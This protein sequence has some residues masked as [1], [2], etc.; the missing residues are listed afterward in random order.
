MIQKVKISDKFLFVNTVNGK[1]GFSNTENDST[2]LEKLQQKTFKNKAITAPLI[3]EQIPENIHLIIQLTEACNMACDYCFQSILNNNDIKT[4]FFNHADSDKLIEQLI[5]FS[6][7]NTT[8]TFS[9]EFTGG[10]PLLKFEE[11]KYFVNSA[12]EKK[13]SINS[14]GIKTNGTIFTKEIAEFASKHNLGICFSID[15]NK[16]SH[17]ERRKFRNGKG[18][19]EVIIENLKKYKSHGCL[20]SNIAVASRAY[21]FE[22]IFSLFEEG[23]FDSFKINKIG[24][25]SDKTDQKE[26]ALAHLNLIKKVIAKFSEE[27]IFYRLPNLFHNFNDILFSESRLKT[28]KI[29][30]PT[31][32]CNAGYNMISITPELSVYPCLEGISAD[33]YLGNLHDTS[34]LLNDIFA[35]KKFLFPFKV[36]ITEIPKCRVCVFSS[37]CKGGCPIRSKAKF[38]S[39][40]KESDSCEYDYQL[41][42]GLFELLCNPD[43]KPQIVNYI[44]K[45][46]EHLGV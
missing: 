34:N 29:Y 3:K 14:I 42:M 21:Q 15:G 37:F 40:Y 43:K 5:Q 11:I 18:T 20:L 25:S 7:N 19:F 45:Y 26:L 16:K 1:W 8:C 36:D 27:N 17:D 22:E 6:E 46:Q 33:N 13:L 12:I 41:Y 4:A 28:N 24:F 31:R 38:N 30:C 44:K 32:N 2:V 35:D 10:E 9:L 39:Y 23:V